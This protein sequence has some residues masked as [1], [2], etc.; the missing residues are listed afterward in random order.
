MN[1]AQFQTL[2]SGREALSSVIDAVAAAPLHVPLKPPQDHKMCRG[3]FQQVQQFNS[4][5]NQN[6]KKKLKTLF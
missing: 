5:K 3:R 4:K 6:Q 1:T 2:S